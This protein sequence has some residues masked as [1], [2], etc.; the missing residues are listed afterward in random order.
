[1]KMSHKGFVGLLRIDTEAGVLRGEVVHINDTITFQ[2]KTVEEAKAAFQES[3]D[4]YLEFCKS[5]NRAPDKTFSGTLV[6]RVSPEMHR[7]VALLA[8]VKGTSVNSLVAHQL[9]RLTDSGKFVA[10]KGGTSKKPAPPVTGQPSKGESRRP[11][12][13]AAR[14][15]RK[16]A[17]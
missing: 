8:K 17:T 7:K 11:R 9:K 15:K 1:M 6:V 12:Q 2:G 3:V 10:G 4:D 14:A 5:L 16:L 13:L